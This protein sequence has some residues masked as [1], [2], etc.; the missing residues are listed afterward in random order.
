MVVA[1]RDRMFLHSK[2]QGKQGRGAHVGSRRCRG[3]CAGLSPSTTP[4]GAGRPMGTQAHHEAR[5]P[6]LPGAGWSHDCT[7][8]ATQ[9]P[10]VTR[11]QVVGESGTCHSHTGSK[12]LWEGAWAQVH[13]GLWATRPLSG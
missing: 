2:A 4:L 9:G 10:P 3:L 1:K 8:T 6:E 7:G 5:C 12:G 13:P 11:G